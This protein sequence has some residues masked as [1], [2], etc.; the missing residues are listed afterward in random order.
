MPFY[1]SLRSFVLEIIS[2]RRS[3]YTGEEETCIIA[4]RGHKKKR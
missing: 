3:R 1:H 4:S 2:I